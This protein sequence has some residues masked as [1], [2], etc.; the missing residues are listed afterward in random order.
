MRKIVISIF[1]IVAGF[2]F[3]LIWEVGTN[4]NVRFRPWMLEDWILSIL[5]LAAFSVPVIYFINW[6]RRKIKSNHGS[7]NL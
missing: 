3:I 6:L 4:G 5:I 7:H 2:V 1:S